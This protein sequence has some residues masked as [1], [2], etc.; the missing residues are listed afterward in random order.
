MSSTVLP[1]LVE[2]VKH[3]FKIFLVAVIFF[4][5]GIFCVAYSICI[6]PFIY[7]LPVN[8]AKKRSYSRSIIRESLRLLFYVTD[9]M[10]LCKVDVINKERFYGN[11]QLIIANH[12]SFLDA[13]IL[14][15]VT[16][17]AVF[18]VKSSLFNNPFIMIPLYAAGYIR[19]IDGIN[20]TSYSKKVIAEG[21]TLILFP[22]GTRSKNN[23]TRFKYQRGFAH[24]A[25][26]SGSDILP[27]SI[28]LNAIFMSK[29]QRWYELPKTMLHFILR[30]HDVVKTEKYNDSRYSRSI[31]ARRLTKNIE[32]KY[33]S[34]FQPVSR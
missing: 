32:K 31:N 21:G 22:E 11:N 9:L 29:H 3:G 7:I 14:I 4:L 28:H 1:L 12:P 25:L 15:S 2:G 24:I 27:V 13:L 19:N 17:E 16:K 33:Y 34:Q 5:S 30:A 8:I 26:E 10:K 20:L 6:I 18:I 23:Q